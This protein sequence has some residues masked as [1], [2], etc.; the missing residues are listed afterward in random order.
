VR[1][2]GEKLTVLLRDEVGRQ[3]W[4][5]GGRPYPEHAEIFVPALS[6]S[7]S[8]PIVGKHSIH[9]SVT[10][11]RPDRIRPAGEA[12]AGHYCSPEHIAHAVDYMAERDEKSAAS[13][14]ADSRRS[15]MTRK[16]RFYLEG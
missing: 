15:P 2:D 1:N 11:K 3:P 7:R 14:E 9:G 16:R 10:I 6:P 8:L 13:R 12:K 4:P 5:V